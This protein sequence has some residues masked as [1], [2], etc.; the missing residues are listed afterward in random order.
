MTRHEAIAELVV[1]TVKGAVEP[2][3]ARNADLE[4]RV[5]QLESRPLLKYAGIHVEGQAYAEC[6]LV[7]RSGGLWMSTKATSTTPGTP[8]SQWRLIVKSGGAV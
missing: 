3:R 8:G 6:Q 2:L 7:T 5:K 1:R 4:A